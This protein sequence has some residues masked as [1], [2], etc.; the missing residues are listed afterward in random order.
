ML[1]LCSCMKGFIVL[2]CASPLFE[3]RA[4]LT[5]NTLGNVIMVFYS[6]SVDNIMISC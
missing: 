6:F 5:D 2:N 1:M 4:M 3:I